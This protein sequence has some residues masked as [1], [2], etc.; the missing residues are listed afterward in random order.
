MTRKEQYLANILRQLGDFLK[1]DWPSNVWI[2]NR[3]L[4]VYVRQATRH[5][6]Y[7]DSEENITC[8]DIASIE[9]M[10]HFRKQGVFTEFIMKAHEFHSFDATY[11]ESILNPLVLQW[12]IKRDWRPH[13][14]HPKYPANCFYLPKSPKCMELVAC[15][16]DFNLK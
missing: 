10:P 13:Y 3:G 15:E 6:F 8:L 2:E 14:H 1:K 4:R 11:I 12:C 16:K 7:P 9:I 5:L